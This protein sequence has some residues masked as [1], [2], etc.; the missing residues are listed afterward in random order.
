VGLALCIAFVFFCILV[1]FQGCPGFD[2]SHMTTR[3]KISRVQPLSDPVVHTASPQRGSWMSQDAYPQVPQL[4]IDKN[5]EKE[6]E[7]D[8]STTYSPTPRS[9]VTATISDASSWRSP[10]SCPRRLSVESHESYG[11][12]HCAIQKQYSESSRRGS[13]LTPD[14][15]SN[16]VRSQSA[17]PQANRTSM[18]SQSQE[19]RRARSSS[20]RPSLRTTAS[21][22]QQSDHRGRSS[23]RSVSPRPLQ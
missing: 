7:C 9:V 5:A 19:H 16:S 2:C 12:V 17:A 1:L 18:D 13:L 3:K 11:A 22:D 10:R 4:K 15:H 6:M 21:V 20:P 23:S 14:T 8:T